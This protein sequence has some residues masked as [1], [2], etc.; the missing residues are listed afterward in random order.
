V[1]GATKRIAE[2][3]IRTINEK[4]KTVFAAVRFGNVIGSNGSVVPKFLEQIRAGG[5]VTITHP[6]MKRYFMLIPEAVH[7]VLHA[8]ALAHDGG[9]FVLEMGEQ[10]RILDLAKNLIR[11]SGLVPEKDIP[12]QT[13]GERPGEKLAEELVGSGES[14]E[15]S[16]IDQIIRVSSNHLPDP[17]FLE[18]EISE[19]E[20]RAQAGDDSGVIRC[21]QKAIPGYRPV[22]L[23][24]AGLEPPH[25]RAR[26]LDRIRNP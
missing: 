25:D 16:G 12:I 13:T 21:L 20:R 14:A 11:L 19:I 8:A 1:M 17:H 23:N 24:E 18:R 4:N 6:E 10:I 15:P 5:P 26:V 7:L 3:L 2:L 22:G 9:T